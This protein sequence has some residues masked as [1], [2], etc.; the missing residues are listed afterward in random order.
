MIELLVVVAI[1]AILAAILL[2]ALNAA[3]ERGMAASC[4][5]NLKQ[6]GNGLAMYA[7]DNNGVIPLR[8]GGTTIWSTM[9]CKEIR[10]MSSG[11]EKLGGDYLP[12]DAVTCPSNK[13]VE[14]SAATFSYGTAYS[15]GSL[16]GSSS[17]PVL[18]D[19]QKAQYN[20][21]SSE[22][23]GGG[24]KVI[25][26]KLKSA[27]AFWL[28]GDTYRKDQDAQWYNTEWAS[29]GSMIMIHRGQGGSMWADGHAT[30]DDA[31]TLYSKLQY[32]VDGTKRFS[33]WSVWDADGETQI[34]K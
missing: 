5:N 21:L 14:T 18:T 27:S 29:A 22:V 33:S 1:I 20:I 30:M 23:S 24:L 13:I 26:F 9:L 17:D 4:I 34:S 10:D 2:P 6:V 12:A 3:N 7:D 19:N 11:F 31:D 25:P 32:E 16:P 8:Y 15:A 28:L